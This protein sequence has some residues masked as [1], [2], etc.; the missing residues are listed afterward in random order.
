[1]LLDNCLHLVMN[2][3]S[4]ICV[5]IGAPRAGSTTLFFQ[6]QT[7]PQICGATK[8]GELC[9]ETDY[10]LGLPFGCSPSGYLSLW[11][12]TE[13]TRVL[14]EASPNYMC[15]PQVSGVSCFLEALPVPVKIIALLRDPVDRIVSHYTTK[16][17]Y[18]SSLI[19]E[20]DFF[21]QLLISDYWL[22][23][24]HFRSFHRKERMYFVLFPEM[25]RDQQRV[26]RGVCDFLEL[27]SGL[28]DLWLRDLSPM[29]ANKSVRVDNALTRIRNNMGVQ[30][31]KGLA[32]LSL[33]KALKWFEF[34][35]PFQ[36]VRAWQPDAISVAWIR[37]SLFKSI[38]LLHEDF[39]VEPQSFLGPDWLS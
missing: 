10:L 12:P 14:L 9:K 37:R 33:K 24:S 23:L 20:R 32:P 22:Q 3:P 16:G 2:H 4:S 36:G 1:M 26:L 27:D 18:P 30:S 6:L 13:A 19:A 5:V 38:N 31:I 7:H 15:Y 28:T 35:L 34:R 39:G 29:H 17:L 11:E 8:G 21:T 25:I